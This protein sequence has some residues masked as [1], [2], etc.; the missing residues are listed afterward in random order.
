MMSESIHLMTLYCEN[1][2]AKSEIDRLFE[3]EEFDSFDY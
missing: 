3:N 2:K 1:N